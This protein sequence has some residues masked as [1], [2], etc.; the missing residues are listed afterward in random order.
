MP[1]DFWSI[2]SESW[3]YTFP[4]SRR[5]ISVI[6][7]FASV[8]NMEL[9]VII[10]WVKNKNLVRIEWW[11]IKH[12]GISNSGLYY[13]YAHLEN[14]YYYMKKEHITEIFMQLGLWFA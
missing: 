12:W 11:I 6:F 8:L 5:S 4:D 10:S 7:N 13:Y 9:D 3:K 14:F 2:T 1:F